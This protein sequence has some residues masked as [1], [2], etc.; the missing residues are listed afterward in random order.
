MA[1]VW[2]RG[3]YRLWDPDTG[4]GQPITGATEGGD[5][6]RGTL[7]EPLLDPGRP[8]GIRELLR[9]GARGSRG[10]LVLIGVLTVVVGL[11]AAV[12]PVVAGALTQTVA[13]QTTSTLL[14]VGCALVALAAGDAMLRGVRMF[15]LLR[16]RG[17]GVAV[18]ATAVWDRL[19]RLPMSWH[20]KRTVASRMTDANAV[21][22]A[23]MIM[24]D[25]TVTALL[26]VAA[27]GGALIGVLFTQ[28]RPGARP[29]RVPGGAGRG[30]GRRGP[31]RRPLDP[32]GP[33]CPDRQSVGGPGDHRRGQ[34][35]S[36]VRRVPAGPS[37][38]GRAPR[39]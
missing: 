11:L 39:R 4:L 10:T 24:P 9:L 14:V 23:S 12:I 32:A 16:I 19:L 1:A 20:S 30:G 29:D 31:D 2:R 17:R 18:S 37:P 8:S 21:D 6:R 27:V 34:P 3:A 36:G 28:H 22:T 25:S 38:A 26:D 13:S 33:G 35:A 7:F 5:A 15:A